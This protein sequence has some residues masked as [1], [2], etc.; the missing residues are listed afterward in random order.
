M[1]FDVSP[2]S[3]QKTC[4]YWLANL[5]IA[6]IRILGS[7]EIEQRE[8]E[9]ESELKFKEKKMKNEKKNTEPY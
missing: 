3:S 4:M 2:S 7:V 6:S 8:E 9:N 5:F 1:T